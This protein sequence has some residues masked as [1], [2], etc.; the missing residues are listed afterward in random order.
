MEFNKVELDKIQ[1]STAYLT[2]T[3][4][5]KKFKFPQIVKVIDGFYGES[6]ESTFSVDQVLCLH[7]IK[8]V[9]KIR[10]HD[11]NGKEFSISLDCQK[12]VEVCPSNLK[13]VYNNVDELCEALPRY[14][15]VSSQG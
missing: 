1:W 5:L 14:V 8:P 11:S 7:S 10:A 9:Q 15:R 13:H 4:F 6:S 2:I 12:K 3:E